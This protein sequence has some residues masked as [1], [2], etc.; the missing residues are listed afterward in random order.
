M[1]LVFSYTYEN[2]RKYRRS[3]SGWEFHGVV[4][5]LEDFRDKVASFGDYDYQAVEPDELRDE[6]KQAIMIDNNYWKYNKVLRP[7]LETFD[8]H[9]ND[10]HN[11]DSMGFDGSKDYCIDYI[12]TW[13]DGAGQQERFK[14]YKGGT[15]SV[16]SSADDEVVYEEVIK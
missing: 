14:N 8:V 9:F 7:L 13:N 12:Q 2:A 1:Y 16:V 3:T 6:Q 10:D 11:S 4:E 5:S 15:V